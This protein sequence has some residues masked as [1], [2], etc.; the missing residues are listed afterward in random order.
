MTKYSTQ[1]AQAFEIPG[2]T[3]GFIFPSHPK[4]EHTIAVISADGMYPEKGYAL[5]DVCT[6]T[7]YVVEGQLVV[8]INS[9]EESVNSGELIMILPGQKYTIRGKAEAIDFITPSWD[10]NQNHI[11]TDNHA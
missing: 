2:G 5:N 1:D 10:K 8:T 9:K 6:E 7:V 3:K 4:G 11:V